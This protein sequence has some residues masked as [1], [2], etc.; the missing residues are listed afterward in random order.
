[1]LFVL[2]LNKSDK[3]REGKNEKHKFK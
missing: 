2:L 3:K 1:L